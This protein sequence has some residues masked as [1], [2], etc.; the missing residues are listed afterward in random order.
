MIFPNSVSF[1][2]ALICYLPSSYQSIKPDTEGNRERPESEIKKKIFE[3]TQ[4]LMNTLYVNRNIIA[5]YA[6]SKLL[7]ILTDILI[8]IAAKGKLLFCIF[9]IAGEE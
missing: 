1:A 8:V 5:S 6:V 9:S 2:A 3:K 4:Y 7:K